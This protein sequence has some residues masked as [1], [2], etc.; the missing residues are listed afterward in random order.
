MVIDKNY[1]GVFSHLEFKFLC[2]TASKYAKQLIPI[3]SPDL[4][5]SGLFTV[6]QDV[7]QSWYCTLV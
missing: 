2:K 7:S 5:K 6:L 4:L 3:K 1:H